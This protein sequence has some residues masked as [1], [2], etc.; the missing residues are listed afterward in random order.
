[1]KLEFF[2]SLWFDHVILD[3]PFI[4][5]KRSYFWNIISKLEYFSI[6]LAYIYIVLVV[7]INLFFSPYKFTIFRIIYFFVLQYNKDTYLKVNV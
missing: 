2:V 6:W 1:M 4:S 7:I 5:I 3:F